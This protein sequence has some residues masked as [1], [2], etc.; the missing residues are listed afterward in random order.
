MWSEDFEI[1]RYRARGLFHD[2]SQAELAGSQADPAENA[3]EAARRMGRWKL[4]G[5]W[6]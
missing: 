4:G 1:V 3:A 6:G 2:K 5:L